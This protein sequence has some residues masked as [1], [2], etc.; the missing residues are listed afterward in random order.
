LPR[1]EAARSADEIESGLLPGG[2]SPSI[3]LTLAK[4]G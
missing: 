3:K 4:H 2:P 1:H